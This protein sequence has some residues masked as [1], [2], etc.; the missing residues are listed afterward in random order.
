MIP[1]DCDGHRRE[2]LMM[3]RREGGQGDHLLISELHI[4]KD[5]LAAVSPKSDLLFVQ[6]AAIAAEPFLFPR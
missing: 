2:R 5:R 3:G 4:Q 1:L 6:A